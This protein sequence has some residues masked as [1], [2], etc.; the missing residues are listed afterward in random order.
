ML[1]EVNSDVLITL[2]INAHQYII[3]LMLIG[4][5]FGLLEEYLIETNSYDTF[6]KDLK[7]LTQMNLASYRHNKPYDYKSI[8]VLPK[9]ISTLSKDDAFIEFW[10]T[11]PVKVTRP[12]GK[13]DMLRKDRKECQNIHAIMTK[14]D[15]SIHDHIMK[16]LKYEIEY[17]E[18]TNSMQWMKRPRSWLSG[19]EWQNFEDMVDDRSLPERQEKVEYGQQLE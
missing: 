3:L 5:A 18:R 8:A 4:D 6:P 2:K 10:E 16:C 19:R 9:F 12:D 15:R 1:K 7:Y 13:V 11:Y 14:G 17:R